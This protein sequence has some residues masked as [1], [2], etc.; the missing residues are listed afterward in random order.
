MQHTEMGI[1]GIGIGVGI[2]CM[3]VV[4]SHHHIRLEKLSGDMPPLL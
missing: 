2:V 3:E 4:T 1:V